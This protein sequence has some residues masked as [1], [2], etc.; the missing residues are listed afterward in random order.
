MATILVVDD[1]AFMRVVLKD[2]LEEGGH[3]V[4]SEAGN[5]KDAVEKYK[6][7]RPDLVTM[8]VKMPDISGVEA[9][10]EIRRVDPDARIIMCTALGHRQMILES[11]RSGAMDF[12]V[13][14]LQPGRVLEAVGKALDGHWHGKAQ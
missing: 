2:I 13:K 11:M 8:D 4:I 9:V 6:A 1:A 14:P 3:T 12:V 7:Y 5:G 10:R